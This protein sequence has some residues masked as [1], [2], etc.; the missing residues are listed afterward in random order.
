M[1]ETLELLLS[2]NLVASG[3]KQRAVLGTHMSCGSD[4]S[5]Y[6]IFISR[7]KSISSFTSQS[8]R[9]S[10]EESRGFCCAARGGTGKERKGDTAYQDLCKR[11]CPV[12]AARET[13]PSQ[14]A[15]CLSVCLP[16]ISGPI[17][18]SLQTVSETSFVGAND[19]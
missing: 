5:R 3:S 1:Q 16:V 12:S 15:Q 19:L 11:S 7:G 18:A 4:T 2:K 13:K 14:G 17:S 6:R 10:T 9:T 8:L